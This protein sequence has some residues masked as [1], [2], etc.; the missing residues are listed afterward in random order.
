MKGALFKRKGLFNTVKYSCIP[1]DQKL[2]LKFLRLCVLCC[3]YRDTIRPSFEIRVLVT[4]SH[5]C[6]LVP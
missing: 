2:E 4:C 5:C 1:L 3:N 6:S